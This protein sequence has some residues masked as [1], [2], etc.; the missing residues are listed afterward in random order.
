[1]LENLRNNA[2]F[3]NLHSCRSNTFIT[4]QAALSRGV[5]LRLRHPHVKACR[6][7]Y[8]PLLHVLE[9]GANNVN[10][11]HEATSCMRRLMHLSS[12]DSQASQYDPQVHLIA[13]TT[14]HQVAY[15]ARAKLSSTSAQ[16]WARYEA[17][18][19][20]G[21]STGRIFCLQPK[22]VMHVVDVHPACKALSV[23]ATPTS[24]SVT[25]AT[26]HSTA[27]VATRTASGFPSPHPKGGE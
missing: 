23:R 12:H 17:I 19:Y 27:A 4:A 6:M 22:S 1:M 11:P 13:N 16:T 9:N 18:D 7:S 3:G 26:Q 25:F 24:S 2:G 21:V 8:G 20:L 5:W 15:S 14:K 10:K